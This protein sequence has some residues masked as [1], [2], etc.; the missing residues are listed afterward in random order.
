MNP[1]SWQ[2]QKLTKWE[3]LKMMIY[4]SHVEIKYWHDKVDPH[5]IS[6][7]DHSLAATLAHVFMR[8]IVC[9]SWLPRQLTWWR[10]N[11]IYF[12]SVLMMSRAKS[13]YHAHV[14][15]QLTEIW[16]GLV[17]HSP[18]QPH[19]MNNKYNNNHLPLF[20]SR[21]RSL[22]SYPFLYDRGVDRS[23]R[24]FTWLWQVSP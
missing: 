20:G 6:R 8:S 7:A 2:L 18:M 22:F 10:F 19:M 14:I 16:N 23:K 11:C 9:K 21:V 5:D 4:T 17:N 24:A 1:H 3:P 13:N 15:I 12:L